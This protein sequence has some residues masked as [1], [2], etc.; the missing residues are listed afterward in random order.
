VIDDGETDWKVICIAVDDPIADK[1]HSIDHVREVMPGA[2]EAL[3]VWLGEYK[4]K[5][6]GGK[7]ESQNHF[8]LHNHLAEGREAALKCINDCSEQW[9]V[10]SA[11]R[12]AVVGA[13]ASPARGGGGGGGP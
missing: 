9:Q 2:V 8:Y 10:E 6:V 4:K 7:T 1:L 3:K 13:V 5:V 11:K 12:T